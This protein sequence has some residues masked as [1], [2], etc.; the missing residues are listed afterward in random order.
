MA[1]SSSTK[2][3][4]PSQSSD[5]LS[6]LQSVDAMSWAVLAVIVVYVAVASP[7]NTPSVFKNS[8]F[9]L[10]V[11][12]FVVVVFVVEGPMIGTMFALAMVLPIVYSNMQ[13]HAEGFNENTAATDD[14]VDEEVDEEVDGED[15]TYL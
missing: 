14:E 15:V 13:I 7:S 6:K 5:L 1:R 10:V 12:A 3:S 2:S 4:I 8:L 11:F 9:R